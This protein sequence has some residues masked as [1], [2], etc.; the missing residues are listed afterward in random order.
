MSEPEMIDHYQQKMRSLNWY[1]L[2]REANFSSPAYGLGELESEGGFTIPENYVH[3][4]ER[5]GCCGFD[6][7]VD[8]SFL[9]TYPKDDRGLISAFFGVVPGDTY[10]LMRNFHIYKHRMPHNLLPIAVDPGGN[11]ICL[12]VKGVNMGYVFFWDHNEETT[13]RD[14][15]LNYSNLYLLARSFDDFINSLEVAPDED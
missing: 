8:F 2:R 3:F 9:E 13:S 10:D 4:L 11:I 6:D 14:Q 5:Y 7:Y 15:E 1:S 12:S